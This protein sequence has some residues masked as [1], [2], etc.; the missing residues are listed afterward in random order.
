[1]TTQ[2]LLTVRE[3]RDKDKYRVLTEVLQVQE[4]LH[5]LLTTFQQLPQ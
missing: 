1:M 2:L 4:Q 5:G 3:E